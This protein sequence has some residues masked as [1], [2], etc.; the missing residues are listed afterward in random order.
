MKIKKL[1]AKY[2]DELSG[3]YPEQEITAIFFRLSEHFWQIN[4]LDLAMNPQLKTPGTELEKA[5]EGLVR[6]RPWQ[7]ITGESLFYGLPFYVNE[8]VLIPRPETEELVN[9]I[10]EDYKN[11]Q[12]PLK[13]IDIG[14][15]SGAIAISLAKHLPKSSVT[16]LDISEKALQTAQKNAKLN[17]VKINLLQADILKGFD[18]SGYDIIVSNPPYVRASEKL[19]MHPNVTQYEPGIALYVSDENPLIFYEKIIEISKK[20]GRKQNL[21]FEINE[22]LQPELEKLLQHFSID[23]YLFKKD[24]FGKWRMLKIF[25]S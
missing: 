2:Q 4:R 23:K 6:H 11:Y 17:Q 10:I 7:Y 5:L 21:Y 16:A 25:M 8:N 19:M 9:W 14:S 15:G 18:L 3:I 24:L 13:I 22:Y 1:L 20:S 12:E